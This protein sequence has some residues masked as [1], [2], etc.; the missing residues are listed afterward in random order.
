MKRQEQPWELWLERHRV[1]V[2]IVTGITICII[3]RLSIQ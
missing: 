1:L 3:L 2:A